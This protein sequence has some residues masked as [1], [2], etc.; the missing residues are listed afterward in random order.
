MLYTGYYAYTNKYRAAGLKTLAVSGV[1]PKFYT[2]G[3]AKLFAPRKGDFIR[4]K[5][6][7]ITN[8]QYIELYKKYLD[9]L[10]EKNPKAFVRIE[11][12]LRS[13][14]FIFLCYEKSGDF[15]HRYALADWLME[16]FDVGEIKEY[17]VK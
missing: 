13:N 17:E 9:R 6:G 11:N 5:N 3:R 8:E 14:N 7:E 1:V 15:C 4:W 2:G 12:T 10:L 16:H